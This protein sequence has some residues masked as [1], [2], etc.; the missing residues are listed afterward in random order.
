[1]NKNLKKINALTFKNLDVKLKFLDAYNKYYNLFSIGPSDQYKIIFATEKGKGI[2]RRLTFTKTYDNLG[3]KK[4]FIEF[5][6]GDAKDFQEA[7]ASMVFYLFS[8]PNAFIDVKTGDKN[9]FYAD[10]FGLY[11][12]E[13]VRSSD[14]KTR[15][16]GEF[17]WSDDSGMWTKEK[18]EIWKLKLAGIFKPTDIRYFLMFENDAGISTLDYMMEL[19]KQWFRRNKNTIGVTLS[20]FKEIKDLRED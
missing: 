14:Y 6:R 8:V 15:I 7:V 16:Q 12:H 11:D 4:D 5:K 20:D 9:Y 18:Y 2:D 1:M 10:I 19:F 3:F 13:Y 17:I